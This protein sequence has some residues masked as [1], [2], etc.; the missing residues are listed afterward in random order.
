MHI[1]FMGVGGCG[2]SG[3]ALMTKSLGYAVSGCDILS[4]PYY[5]MVEDNGVDCYIGHSVDHL[6]GVDVL[7]RSSAVPDDNVEVFK[8][9]EEGIK[10]YT[11]GSFLATLLNEKP[12]IGVAGSHGKTTT[13][14]MIYH[15]LKKAGLKPSIY[16]GGKSDGASNIN[17]DTPI[18]VELDESDGTIFEVDPEILLIN[19]LELEHME[20]FK[21]GENMLAMFERYLIRRKGKDLIIGRGYEMSDSL[22]SLFQAHSFPSTSEIKSR[23]GYEN[24]STGDF[25]F[26]DGKWCL[27]DSGREYFAGTAKDAPHMLQNRFSSML[28]AKKYLDSTGIE[29]P[30]LDETFWDLLP[31]VERRFQIAGVYRKVILIDD[32]AH[33]PTE[34]TAVVEQAEIKY[35]NFGL[36]FQPHRTSRFNAFYEQFKKAVTIVGPLIILPVFNPEGK[37]E[38][39]TSLNLYND[40]LKSGC[41]DVYYFSSIEEAGSF[42][43]NDIEKLRVSALICVGAGDLNNI[44]KHLV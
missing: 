37:E 9:K 24:I 28:A 34:I 6:N 13:A 17:G 27:T 2:V 7:V 3:L 1:H 39:L 31:P 19:N 40:L 15:V 38:G 10:V 36:I 42:L 32:Y 20:F 4:S 22:C 18:I 44:F 11:R 35:K 30:V 21:T 43:K 41:S 16:A 26:N 14:W 33:H 12:V 23:E 8:A 29:M 5:K 25:L